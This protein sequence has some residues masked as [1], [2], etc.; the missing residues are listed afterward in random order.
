[1]KVG[2]RYANMLHSEVDT[3]NKT[4]REQCRLLESVAFGVD[5]THLEILNKIYMHNE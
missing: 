5:F 4:A 2:G 1:M 3:S